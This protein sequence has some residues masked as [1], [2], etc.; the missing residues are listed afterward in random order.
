VLTLI[1]T[2]ALLKYNFMGNKIISTHQTFITNDG[3]IT[4]KENF[5]KTLISE[6]PSYIKSYI[7]DILDLANIN[8][9]LERVIFFTMIKNMNYENIVRFQKFDKD[10]IAE[11]YNS[12]YATVNNALYKLTTKYNFIKQIARGVY[13]VNPNYFGKGKWIDIKDIVVKYNQYGKIIFFEKN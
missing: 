6:E 13:Y 5:T 10:L 1:T 9:K 11:K 4:E 12:T 2:F 3:E 7:K 8:G